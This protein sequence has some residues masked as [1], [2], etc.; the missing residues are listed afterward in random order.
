MKTKTVNIKIVISY[1]DNRNCYP[2]VLLSLEKLLDQKNLQHL[3]ESKDEVNIRL[4]PQETYN[5]Q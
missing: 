3:I 4:R 1:N 5:D 2:A